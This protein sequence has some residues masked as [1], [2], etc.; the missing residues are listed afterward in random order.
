MTKIFVINGGQEFAHSGGKFNKTLSTWT[1]AFFT[2][3][4]F[5]VK[6]TNINDSYDLDQEVAK[7]VWADVVIYHTPIWWFHVPHKLKE[8]IDLVFTAGHNKGIY[9]NDGRSHKNPAINYGTGGMLHGRKYMLTTTWNAPATAFTI[10]G[11]F[12]QEKNVDDGIMFGFH[13]MNA[14]TGMDP[15]RSFHFHDLEKNATVERILNYKKQYTE[16]LEQTFLNSTALHYEN[17]HNSYI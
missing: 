2:Q 14:F 9:K 3:H 10:P 12:F 4:G 13:R 5:E 11:E 1:A 15:L 6:A 17:R 8:Y 7:F 16:H